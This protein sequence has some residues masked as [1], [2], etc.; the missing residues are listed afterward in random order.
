MHNNHANVLVYDKNNKT[1]SQIEHELSCL[2]APF[3]SDV[4]IDEYN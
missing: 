3:A 1:H 4:F 2:Y